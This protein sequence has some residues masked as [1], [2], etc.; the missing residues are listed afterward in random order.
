M[1][2]PLIIYHK[3]CVDGAGAALAAWLKFGE[4]AE[5]RAAQYGDAAPTDDEVRG[6]DVFVLDF[7]YGRQET[8]RL[9][10]ACGVYKLTPSIDRW[11]LVVLDHHISA[12]KELDDLPFCTFDMERS[13]AVMA[14]EH[15]H[16][17]GRTFSEHDGPD[18][19]VPE[20]F[21][22]IQDR[23]LFTRVLPHTKEISAALAT[24]GALQDF[25]ALIPIYKDW[26]RGAYDAAMQ[27]LVKDGG[28]ILRTQA[29]MIET[30]VALA[31][32]VEIPFTSEFSP[33][34]HTLRAL[35]VTSSVLQ[36][37]IGDALAIEAHKRGLHAIG[38]IYCRDGNKKLWRVSMRSRTIDNDEAPDVSI[39]AKQYGGGGH[40]KAA[41]FEVEFLPWTVTN[42]ID[43]LRNLVAKLRPAMLNM[44]SQSGPW[45][46][47][48]FCGSPVN[49]EDDTAD[50]ND[51]RQWHTKTCLLRDV[52]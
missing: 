9:A 15:F 30:T 33:G 39:I 40:A 16:L 5:Y 21:R 11:R 36:T 49:D 7:H 52:K 51:D 25:R 46:E 32:E 42:E 45:L 13:G 8:L 4:E 35:A 12:Q 2:K 48:P 3:H 43:S 29:Q 17:R 47:C 14:W 10:T 20:L 38:I 37:D 50:E 26:R 41:G 44:L 31:E 28:A 18:E 27:S 23:D 1:S 34:P 19:H 24:S 6:R 22:Y